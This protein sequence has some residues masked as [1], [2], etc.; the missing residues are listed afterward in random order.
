MIFKNNDEKTWL[1]DESGREIAR[2]DH[3]VIR[4]GVVNILHT[5]VD[6]SYGGQGIA[7]KIT[8]ELADRLRNEGM[9]AELSCS[10]AIKWFSTHPDY[11]DVVV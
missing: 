10:Y 6:P 11:A 8:Q 9:K 5:E 3:S 2:I 7:G 4:P 1:E